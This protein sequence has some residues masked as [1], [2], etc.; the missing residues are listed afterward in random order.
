MKQFLGQDFLLSSETAKRLYFEHAESMPIYDYHCHIPPD[1]IASN[2]QFSNLTEIWLAGD[3]YKWRAM[4][5]N[6][7]AEQKITGNTTDREKFQAWAET[8][9]HTIGNPLYHWTHLELQKPFGI[10]GVLL[11]GKTAQDIWD[12]T[13]R[14]L[15]TPEFSTG[16]ILKQ[17]NVRFICTTDDPSDD[18]AHHRAIAADPAITTRVV[19]GFR[20]D[21]ALA[22]EEPA[23]FRAY[24]EK[25]GA[26]AEISISSLSDLKRALRARIDVFHALGS[27]I[28]D[29][30]LAL[31]VA[32]PATESEVAAIFAG[33]LEGTAPDSHDAEKY[34]T[35]MMIF[36]GRIYHELDWAFQ[37]HIGALRNTNSRMFAELG[38]DT[39]FDSMGDG[40]IAAPLARLLDMLEQ[41]GQLPR[42]IF[43]NVNPRDNELLASMTGNFQDGSI[44]GKIQFGSGWWYNDQKDGMQRQML[45]LANSGLLSRFVGMLTDSRS[46]LSYPRHEYFRR[47]LCDLIGS[48]VENGEAPND[49][50]LLGRM[51]EDICWNN[52]VNY[53]GIEV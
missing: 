21:K 45:A 9:P 1:K 30:A 48:W 42:T 13:S 33:A 6:G 51:V 52:A 27:R 35:H 50:Q 31:P 25:L 40:T 37:L 38:P 16:G 20:P 17:M 18:L 29:H 8:V 7:V 26:A 19:P 41:T 53:F 44:P 24:L 2:H 36:L 34:R 49:M 3:H 14:M 32:R 4:R 47:I 10:E 23:G 15:A 22:I 39:G 5:A 28:S 43:Y 46:F 11:D 12:R